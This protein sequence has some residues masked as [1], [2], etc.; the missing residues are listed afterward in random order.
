M[1]AMGLGVW[2]LVL[3]VAVL[4]LLFGPTRL[5]GIGKGFGAA[6]RNFRRETR[7]PDA[8]DVTP[9]RDSQR[10]SDTTN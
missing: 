5:P 4:L 10:E 8:I 6:M 7:K 3:I 2:E 9:P 1:V